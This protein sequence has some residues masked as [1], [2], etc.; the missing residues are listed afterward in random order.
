[1]RLRRTGLCI[2]R[3]ICVDKVEDITKWVRHRAAAATP[4]MYGDLRGLSAE[5][6]NP[7]HGPVKIFCLDEQ[8]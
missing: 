3:L 1:M 2:T 4:R 7:L 8:A 5:V 6:P